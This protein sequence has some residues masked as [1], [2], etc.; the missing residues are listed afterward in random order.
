VVSI[1]P[2]PAA[3]WQQPLS[4]AAGPDSPGYGPALGSAH[5]PLCILH[6]QTAGSPHLWEGSTTLLP[7]LAST[8]PQIVFPTVQHPEGQRLPPPC[9]RRVLSS[10]FTRQ[11]GEAAGLGESGAGTPELRAFGIT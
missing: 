5:H 8:W 4:Q 3:E 2:R 11:T 6:S 7:A 10:A 9:R 1:G